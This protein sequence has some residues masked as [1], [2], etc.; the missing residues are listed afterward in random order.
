MVDH[1]SRGFFALL[2]AGLVL[3]AGCLQEAPDGGDENAGSDTDA[4]TDWHRALPE[5]ITGLDHVSQVDGVEEAAGIA[6][7]KDHLYV[8]GLG[9]GFYIL[10]VTTP[11]DPA[12]VGHLVDQWSRGV[13]LVHYDD[14]TIVAA[15]AAGGSGMAFYNV[16]DPTEPV[17]L[18]TVLEGD[19]AVHNVYTLPGTQY[20]YNSRSLDVPGVDIVDASDPED[21]HV[22]AVVRGETTCHD[23]RFYPEGDRGYCAA[24]EQTQVWDMADPLDPQLVQAIVNPAIQIHHWA[25]P[26]HNGTLLVIGDEFA[27]STGAA[28]GCFAASEGP[29]VV[30]TVS[31]PV[32]AVWFY[33]LSDESA[34]VPLGFLAPELPVDNV[35]PAPCTAH[36]GEQ[37]GDRDLMVVGWRTAGTV[38][39]DFSDPMAASIVDVVPTDGDVWEARYLGGWVF[40]GDTGRGSDVL[41]FTG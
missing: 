40:T 28:A 3:L 4:A 13:D 11:E 14:G 27:G 36:F 22:A 37:V 29:D 15:L 32:G 12:L 35:P 30:G 20:V 24:V 17:H 19:V 21:I 9:T 25:M 10:N 5:S 41:T 33:D 16:T 31:D 2:L 18:E 39:V 1:H 6:T 23:I 8:A 38:L 34:P 7:Y 26:V